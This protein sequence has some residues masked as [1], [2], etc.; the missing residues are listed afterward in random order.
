MARIGKSVYG[1]VARKRLAF[2]KCDTDCPVEI[3]AIQNGSKVPARNTAR[4][5][6]VYGISTAV[7]ITWM[8][9]FWVFGLEYYPFT[10][11]HMFATAKK[12][13]MYYKVLG[14][15]KSGQVR[16]FR[17]EDTLGAMAINSRYEPLF[18]LCFGKPTEVSLCKKT[19]AI[20]TSAYNRKVPPNEALAD[21]E[22]QRWTWDYIANP[23]DPA[24]GNLDASFVAGLSKV[25]SSQVNS[26]PAT[27]PN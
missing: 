21:I 19:L 24:Y 7:L 16:P 6:L 25:E 10:D 2:V 11:M 17:L 3:L 27:V 5:L 14:H 13:V 18:D 20:L 23:N 1:Y 8:G 9:T 12:S 26:G 22:I 15:W 4:A